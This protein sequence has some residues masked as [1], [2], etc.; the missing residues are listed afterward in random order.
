MVDKA[1]EP[2]F[3][4]QFA[5]YFRGDIHTVISDP[6]GVPASNIISLRDHFTLE[7][8]WDMIGTMVGSIGGIWHVRAYLESIGPGPEMLIASRDVKMTGQPHYHEAFNIDPDNLPDPNIKKISEGM[9][10]L[11][12]VLTSTNLLGKPAP[13]AGYEEGNIL[14]FFESES[15]EGL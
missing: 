9:Y 6:D 12:I 14:Q 4:G 10:K 2:T 7:V 3:P 5:T 1:F 8:S 15:V 11:G 13:F